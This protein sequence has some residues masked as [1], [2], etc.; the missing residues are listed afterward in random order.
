MAAVGRYVKMKAREGQGSALAEV[1]LRVA[2]GIRSTPGC[3]LYVINRAH[4]EPDVVWVNELWQSQEAVDASLEVLKTKA[5]Q[6][7]MA[8]VLERDFWA[9]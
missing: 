7:R 5:G 2:E 3:L 9:A 4:D 8:E 6:A 1:M